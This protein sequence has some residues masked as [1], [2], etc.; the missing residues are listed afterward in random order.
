ML[1]CGDTLTN[2]MLIQQQDTNTKYVVV[3]HNSLLKY[4]Y[5]SAQL[6]A[7]TIGNNNNNTIILGGNNNNNNI[8]LVLLV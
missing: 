1:S 7:N 8:I 5:S 3:S 2:D 6:I 4:I